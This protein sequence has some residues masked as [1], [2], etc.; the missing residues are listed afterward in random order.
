MATALI[1]LLVASV[2]LGAAVASSIQG[3]RERD[4]RLLRIAAA[5][6][7]R[8][9]GRAAIG[10][11]RGIAVAYRLAL[12]GE[13]RFAQ[14]WTEVAI[15]LPRVYP[16]E[17]HVRRHIGSDRRRIESGEMVDV[18]VGD[19]SFDPTF[20]VEAAPADVARSLLDPETRGYLMS[21][22]DAV[23]DTIEHQ[24]SKLLRL[25]LPGWHEDVPEAVGAVATVARLVGRVRDAFAEAEAKQAPQ[26]VGSPF[27]AELDDRDARVAAAARDREV[28]ELAAIRS[29]RPATDMLTTWIAWIA[30]VVLLG[31]I[32]AV[33][34]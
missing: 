21:H 28:A 11:Y 3:D 10:R 14:P 27:R 18:E 7:G 13:G 26:V 9:E 15:A 33:S 24:G 31:T 30:A 1:L 34:C 19:R 25:S 23:L 4:D 8:I 20:L 12:R 17:L 5:I 2:G 29:G 16:L 6:G 32:V 22:A